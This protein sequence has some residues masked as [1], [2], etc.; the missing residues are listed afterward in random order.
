MAAPGSGVPSDLSMTNPE[1]LNRCEKALLDKPNKKATD[2]NGINNR[3]L[4]HLDETCGNG[5]PIHRDQIQ[6]INAPGQ[7]ADIHKMFGSCCHI[8]NP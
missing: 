4:S 5:L 8:R 2:N 6:N 7:N 1:N 3:M